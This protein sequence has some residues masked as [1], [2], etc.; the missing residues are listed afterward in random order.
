MELISILLPA[1]IDLVNKRI[2]NSDVRFWVSVA[3]CAV[4]GA[5]L[6]F[7]DTGF[8]F[9]TPQLAFESLTASVMTVFGIA[10]LSYKALWE[11]SEMREN[12]GLKANVDKSGNTGGPNV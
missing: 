2:A 1:L 9:A 6:N 5:F 7:L 3:I 12:L 11:K 4:F 8:K 10:Q